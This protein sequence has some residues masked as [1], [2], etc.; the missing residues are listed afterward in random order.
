MSENNVVLFPI[1]TV[2]ETKPQT[3][4]SDKEIDL[5][6]DTI[7][8]NVITNFQEMGYDLSHSNKNIGMIIESIRS[9][10]YQLNYKEHPFQEFAEHYFDEK[11]PGTLTIRA[12]VATLKVRE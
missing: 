1:K 3:E 5:F 11:T 9:M 6:I 7:G 4:L 10:A 2:N 12:S 8:T